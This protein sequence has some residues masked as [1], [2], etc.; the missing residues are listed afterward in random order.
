MEVVECTDEN[1]KVR[2][3][4]CVTSLADGWWL[5]YWWEPYEIAPEVSEAHLNGDITQQEYID[6]AVEAMDACYAAGGTFLETDTE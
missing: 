4:S 1:P 2:C 6:V 5:Q 3:G